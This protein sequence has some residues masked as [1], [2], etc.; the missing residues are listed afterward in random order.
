LERKARRLLR[1]YGAR[2]T[3]QALKAPRRLPGNARGKR[4][5][6]SGNQQTSL[7]QPYKKNCRHLSAVNDLMFN[8]CISDII[9]KD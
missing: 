1:E 6:W 2:E 9:R 4:S 7:T 5:A 3:P 8:D